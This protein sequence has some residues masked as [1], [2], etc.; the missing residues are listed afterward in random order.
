VCAGEFIAGLE[1]SGEIEPVGR[2]VMDTAL[3]QLARWHGRFDRALRIAINV[4]ARELCESRLL[5]HMR[6]ALK[7]WCI[8][9]AHVEL[10]V[11][12]SAVVTGGERALLDEL[13]E[14]GVRI[15]VDDFGTGYSSLQYLKLLP[16]QALK[17]D[18]GFVDGIPSSQ[19]DVAII[20]A[21]LALARSLGLEVVAE[22]VES[23]T[24]LEFLRER[25]CDRVQGYL[26]GK[27]MSADELTELLEAASAQRAR[28]TS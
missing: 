17:I 1:A 16:I 3:E 9:P 7:R 26:I 21:T 8:D 6:Q 23:E 22:G 18:R 19:D 11:T 20:D 10:E 24:Q 12:E 13:H 15:T 2:W 25:G 14:L 28:R 4:S 5:T 27:P